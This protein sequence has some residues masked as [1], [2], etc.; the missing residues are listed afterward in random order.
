M[1][2][3]ALGGD[4]LGAAGGG[5]GPGEPLVVDVLDGAVCAEGAGRS[6]AGAGSVCGREHPTATR[7]TSDGEHLIPHMLEG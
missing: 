4:T 3:T 5:A 7:R 1:A 6:R 2:A